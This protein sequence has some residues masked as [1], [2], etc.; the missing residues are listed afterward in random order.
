MVNALI[1]VKMA[2]IKE[3]SYVN[4]VMKLVK[5]VKVVGMRTVIVAR[6]CIQFK[7]KEWVN[8]TAL[9]LL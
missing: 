6:D 9:L 2:S 8:A 1:V 3:V 7:S 4:L 5:H